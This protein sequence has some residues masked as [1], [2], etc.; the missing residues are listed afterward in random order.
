M[1]QIGGLVALLAVSMP[2]AGVA[3]PCPAGVIEQLDGLYRWQLERQ[4]Q[5]GPMLLASQLP[6]FTP[7]LAG[8]LQQATALTPADGRFIDFDL[9]SGTQV[10]TFGAEVEGC[11]GQSSGAV[12][13]EVAVRAG[14]R[15]RTGD[16]PQQL[17]YVMEPSP[18]QG[19]RIADVVYPG[20]PSFGLS[21]YLEQL[22]APQP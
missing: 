21:T 17:R 10:E 14:L 18:T 2:A 9:F 16:A 19:W 12:V 8:L 13:A 4:S 5:P 22:L 6:R 7:G 20:E 1:R 15:G 11:M 3:A